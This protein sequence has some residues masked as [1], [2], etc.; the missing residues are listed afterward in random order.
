MSQVIQ[1]NLNRPLH[2]NNDECVRIITLLDE[3]R[4]MSHTVKM[5]SVNHLRVAWLDDFG[6]AGVIVG[7]VARVERK[8][9]VYG[10]S[11]F[12]SNRSWQI[13]KCGA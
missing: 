1:F 9:Q 3:G 12:S 8:Q 5:F 13:E 11:V 6:K 7:D 10:M 4:S 2:L